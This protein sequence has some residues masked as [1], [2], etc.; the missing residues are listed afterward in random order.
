VAKR[1]CTLGHESPHGEAVSWRLKLFHTVSEEV[2]SE[3]CMQ[4][5][6]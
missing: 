3:V 2:F 5:L 6:V 4:D 1:S